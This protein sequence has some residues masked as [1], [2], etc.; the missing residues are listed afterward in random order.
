MYLDWDAS[1]QDSYYAG[2]VIEIGT[3]EDTQ[4]RTIL[5]Y[6]GATRTA[7]VSDGTNDLSPTPAGGIGYNIRFSV[8]VIDSLTGAMSWTPRQTNTGLVDIFVTVTDEYSLADTLIVQVDV[9]SVNDKPES[10]L[11]DSL[12]VVEWEEDTTTTITLS[13][14]FF[15][16]D[17]GIMEENG[18]RWNVVILDT[19]ELDEDFPLGIVIPGPGTSNELHAKIAREYIGFDPS[20]NFTSQNLTAQ[21]IQQLNNVSRNPLL[22][23]QISEVDFNGDGI[24]DSTEA[25]FISDSNYYGAG[26]SI[27]FIGTDYLTMKIVLIVKFVIPLQQL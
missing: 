23:V 16:V 27:I 3:D 2:C 21:R 17:N 24:M 19:A 26:H 1:R 18:F 22:D 7:T 25:L 8:P 20:M 11:G 12:S 9:R 10:I 4:V 14:Y 5:A 13:K 6:D 15:D